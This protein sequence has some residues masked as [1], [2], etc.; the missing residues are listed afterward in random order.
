M[1]GP[2]LQGVVIRLG[3]GKPAELK[4]QKQ[5]KMEVLTAVFPYRANILLHKYTSKRF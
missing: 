2:Y 4:G 3:T 1:N 5:L